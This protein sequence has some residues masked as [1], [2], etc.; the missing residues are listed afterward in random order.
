MISP[1]MAMITFAGSAKH[2]LQQ[3]DPPP[4]YMGSPSSGT[5]MNSPIQSGKPS[6]FKPP[7]PAAWTHTVTPH[8]SPQQSSGGTS[9]LSLVGV[10]N[11]L[12]QES[13]PRG[14]LS[15]GHHRHCRDYH[16]L[17]SL[18]S[19]PS[20]SCAGPPAATAALDTPAITRGPP[21]K[22]NTPPAPE[23]F[24]APLYP[25]LHGDSP[26]SSLEDGE[27]DND[28]GVGLGLGPGSP[29]T[30]SPGSSIYTLPT[31]D[32]GSEDEEGEEMKTLQPKDPA[33]VGD[34]DETHSPHVHGLQHLPS[35]A[36]GRSDTVVSDT[37]VSTGEHG[38]S[39]RRRSSL[40]FHDFLD[41]QVKD[42]REGKRFLQHTSRP[43]C[44]VQVVFLCLSTVT[45]GTA[46]YFYLW[47]AN[48][49]LHGFN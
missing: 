4:S 19:S 30:K 32:A 7:Q 5:P 9:S 41:L 36:R 8:V 16:S 37:V 24:A 14:V 42:Y 31:P 46:T 20:Q 10:D 6:W 44:A 45:L 43:N 3:D 15:P 1:A 22:E 25:H 2:P 33:A 18:S 28:P 48:H 12:L 47:S 38:P 26:P 17:S 23:A 11:A 39:G 29:N 21:A 13:L 40:T 49:C 27:Y 35:P 34:E